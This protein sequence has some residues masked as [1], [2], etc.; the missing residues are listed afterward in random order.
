[1]RKAIKQIGVC[2]LGLFLICFIL[3]AVITP[4]VNMACVKAGWVKEGD[5]KLG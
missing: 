2:A 1:M 3:P 4:L 5:M